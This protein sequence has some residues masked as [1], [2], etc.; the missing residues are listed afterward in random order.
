MS[1]FV[2][3]NAFGVPTQGAL[4]TVD[5]PVPPDLQ[6]PVYRAGAWVSDPAPYAVQPP[7][8]RTGAATRIDDAVAAIYGRFTRFESEYVEREAQAKAFKNAGYTGEVPKRVADFCVPADLPPAAAADLILSQAE[9]LRAAQDALSAL[10]MR[11]YEVLRA[12]SDGAA[13]ALANQLLAQIQV[14][15]GQVS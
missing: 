3:I 6:Y 9:A 5:G 1:L 8:D 4:T 15:G 10:R 11:K 12:S 13:E 2:T 7:Y 14:V